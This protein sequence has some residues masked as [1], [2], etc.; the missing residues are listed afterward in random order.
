VLGRFGS[1][2]HDV[3]HRRSGGHGTF[4]IEPRAFTGTIV[5]AALVIS[6]R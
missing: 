4:V 6:D 2:G 1:R 5:G 3:N